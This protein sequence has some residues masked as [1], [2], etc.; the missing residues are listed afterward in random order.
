MLQSDGHYHLYRFNSFIEFADD[1]TDIPI[2]LVITNPIQTMLH[3]KSFMQL[4]NRYP[5]M[6][7]V[8]L[9]Y[10]F[11]ERETLNQFN[12]LIQITD[13]L[14]II[15]QTISRLLTNNSRSE[16]P[17]PKEQLTNR[18]IDI[19]RHIVQGLSNKEIA[20]ELN[21]STHTVISHRKNIVQ[22]T[23]IKSQAGLTIYAISNN[24]INLD[25]QSI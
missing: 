7:W 25:N 22:K 20:N 21:I 1:L 14:D 24:I 19:L 6:L 15:S 23:G 10:S 5:S 4:K 12:T 8:G 3:A 9:L 11:H 2:D 18:E 16:T 13:P 17:D